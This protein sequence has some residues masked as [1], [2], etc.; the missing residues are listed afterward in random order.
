MQIYD[1]RITSEVAEKVRDQALYIAQDKPEVAWR[2]YENVFEQF[3]ALS[4]M[5]ERC[6]I[7]AESQYLSFETRQLIIG[8]YR[9]LFFIDDQTVVISDFKSSWQSH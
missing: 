6:P 1:V 2:W 4:D 9:V 8:N 3:E 5:P 7:A